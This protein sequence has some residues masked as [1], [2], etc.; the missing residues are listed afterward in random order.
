LYIGSTVPFLNPVLR[1]IHFQKHGHKFG[2]SDEFH[3]ERMAD[4]FMNAPMQLGMH[5]GTVKRQNGVVDR[6]RLQ[7][8]TLYY[9]VIYNVSV[10][11]SF[12][13]RHPREITS[14]GGAAG[15]I[16]AKCSENWR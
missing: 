1:Q 10:V 11:R 3:Y 14:H 2:A 8:V 9:G 13:P 5:E 7:E 16:V 4:A 12:Y 15:F 6:L